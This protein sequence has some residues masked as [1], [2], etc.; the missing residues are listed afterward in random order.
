MYKSESRLYTNNSEGSCSKVL[1]NT[2]LW[3]LTEALICWRACV[4]QL[5]DARQTLSS[6]AIKLNDDPMMHDH[7]M[8]MY[9]RT[10]TRKDARSLT[11][12][13]TYIGYDLGTQYIKIS[14][15]IIKIQTTLGEGSCKIK[16]VGLSVSP[17]VVL[18]SL[19]L[20]LQ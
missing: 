6:R 15:I 2:V 13:V 8:P 7:G 10:T 11:T 5:T 9:D 3:W 16:L 17:C 14:R 18:G 4:T 20:V 19:I 1:V 12:T